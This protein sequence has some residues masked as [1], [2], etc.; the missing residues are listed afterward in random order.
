MITDV[1]K[2]LRYFVH[3]R[4]VYS[5]SYPVA[6]SHHAAFLSP[7]N[8]NQQTLERFSLQVTPRPDDLTEGLDYFGNIRHQFSIAESH[9]ELTVEMRAQVQK[10]VRAIPDPEDSPSAAEV[11]RFLVNP[12]TREGVDAADFRFPSEWTQPKDEFVAYARQFIDPNRPYLEGVKRLC[13]GI[14]QDF[15]FDNEAT[16]INTPLTEFFEKRGGVCQ[17]FAHF[18][19]A[20]LRGMGFAAGYVSGYILTHPPE[21]QPRLEGA[22]AS[23]AWVTTYVPEIGWVDLDPANALFVN[24]EHIHV[25]RGRDYQ[26]VA[27]IKGAVSGGGEQEIEISVTVRPEWEV[28]ENSPRKGI[29]WEDLM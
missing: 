19:I 16:D 22:D 17:D 1:N 6:I 11:H 28:E 20:C 23:H 21:E 18:M 4:T 10:L 13:D 2:A 5:Y 26:D 29:Y 14:H 7:L 8:S 3:H 27:P 25:A 15:D 24:E 12:I 9:S